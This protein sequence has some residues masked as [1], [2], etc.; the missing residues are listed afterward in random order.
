MKTLAIS[1]KLR[2]GTGKTD[3]KALRNQGNVPCVLYGGEKQVCFYAHENDFRSLVYTPDVFI[4]ELDIEGEKFRVVM[5]DLQFHPVTDKLLHLDF[6]QI[7]DDKEV[8]MT[9]PVHLK[10][11]SIGI[12]NGGVL[13]F[14]RR[15]IITR[16]IPGNLPD[17]IEINIADL[18]IGHSVFIK[19]LRV[20]EYTF[21]APDNAVVVGVRTAR[22]LIIEE[23][24]EEELEGEEGV[25]GEEGAEGEATE[26]AG[27]VA[28]SEGGEEKPTAE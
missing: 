24:E 19:D 22:E 11:M 1:A 15:K 4:V 28:P 21:L 20:D 3:S 12:R 2:N 13:S 17:Y 10:G 27:E 14:R 7:F 25:E 8:T 26:G 5:Q 9:I 18:D 16:A 23:E 6:L